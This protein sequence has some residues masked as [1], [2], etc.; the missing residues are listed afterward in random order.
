MEFTKLQGLGNDFIL[1]D[2]R[3]LRDMDW[4]R[5][6]HTIC[7][8]RFGVGADGLLLLMN[9]QSADFR[10]RMFNPDGS[11]SEACG[12][13]LRCLV[14]FIVDY[15][16]SSKDLL[17]IETMAGIRQA[18]LQ[19]QD[20]IREKIRVSMGNP[21]FIPSKIPV[22]VD[23]DAGDVIDIML[24]NYPIS[25]DDKLLKLNFVSMGNP[26]AVLFITEPVHEFP[27]IAVGPKIEKDALFPQ[28]VNFEVARIL[29]K[30]RI[31]MRVWERGA[32]ET[33]ACGSGACA[34]A[35]AAKLL[36]LVDNT[37]EIK[38]PGG[39]AEVCWDGKGEVWLTGPAE[40]VFKGCW[41]L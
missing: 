15:G 29:D 24:G 30:D 22:A 40:I 37:V 23:F 35:V 13:G 33:L 3:E 1:I 9:A 41:L 2:A 8:R 38:L 6:A 7:N 21:E 18:K 10:M 31:E 5:L 39:I 28:G 19:R 11:E 27:L 14:R 17:S 12:N 25:V 32:G 20:G 26:H 4:A 34:V 16:L 36:K